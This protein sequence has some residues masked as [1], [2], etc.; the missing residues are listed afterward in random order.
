MSTIDGEGP[1]RA[2]RARR[3]DPYCQAVMASMYGQRAAGR[4]FGASWQVCSTPAV[5]E[6]AAMCDRLARRQ[7]AILRARNATRI[8]RSASWASYA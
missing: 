5:C 7:F 6:L 2:V 1:R 4:V 8:M 3:F